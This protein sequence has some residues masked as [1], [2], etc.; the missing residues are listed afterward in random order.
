MT[1]IR[2]IT[3]RSILDSRGHPTIEA[4][5]ILDDGAKGVAGIPSGASTGKREAKELR[6]GGQKWH[7][8]G[9][10]QAIDFMHG[11]MFDALCGMNG[12]RQ[13]H[14]D[15]IMIDLD[16]TPDK[17]RLGANAILGISLALTRAMANSRRI[18]L[19]QYIGGFQARDLPAPMMNVLNGGAHADNPLDIQEI[20]I[21]PAGFASFAE[22]LRAGSEI[23]QSLKKQLTTQKMSVNVGDEGGFAPHINAKQGLELLLTAIGDAGYRAG[24]DVFLAIDVAAS[25]FFEDNQYH[26]KGEGKVF[27]GSQMVEWLGDLVSQYPIISIEDG[28]AEDDFEGW[29]IIT[30]ALGDKANLVGD[31]LFTTNPDS[32]QKGIAS[33]IANAVLIK[34]NQ[35]GSI[36][37]TAKAIEIAKKGGFDCVMSHR[38]GETEDTSIADLAVGFGTSWIKTG[39]LARSERTA[40]YNRLLSIEAVLGEGAYYAGL[41]IR[42]RFK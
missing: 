25:E 42:D 22:A 21:V 16:G 10:S 5:V 15:Q 32:I 31:D 40:K 28:M 19:F 24:D 39:S 26:M 11:E 20:M 38:S 7:G 36:S 33:Q 8:R 4:C 37:E 2:Q 41:D 18:E 13:Q 1:A 6:D 29:Q 17:S 23:F 27:S 14:I 9:V 30:N 34:P 3:A 12:A 35:I